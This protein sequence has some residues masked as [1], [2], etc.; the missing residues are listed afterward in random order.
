M[1]SCRRR[2]T[3]RRR[4]PGSQSSCAPPRR[5]TAPRARSLGAQRARVIGWAAVGRPSEDRG[6]RHACRKLSVT[7]SRT[8]RRRPSTHRAQRDCRGWRI[9]RHE[10]A[11]GSLPLP[12]QSERSTVAPLTLARDEEHE[13]RSSPLPRDE[14]SSPRAPSPTVISLQVWTRTGHLRRGRARARFLRERACRLT[15][16]SARR[17]S[18]RRSS[19]FGSPRRIGALA[20][21]HAAGSVGRPG[22]E[23][24]RGR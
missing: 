12:S 7:A 15:I 13:R 3:R 22:A 8:P 16:R 23:P 19:A 21:G 11:R 1:P 10:I 2:R 24:A 9:P 18:G 14:W 6:E 4:R 20:G 5:R 17:S